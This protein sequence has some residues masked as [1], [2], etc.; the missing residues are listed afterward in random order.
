MIKLLNI[1][2]TNQS[3]FG[4]F[5]QRLVIYDYDDEDYYE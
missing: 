1:S 3:F 4:N 5:K 2:K